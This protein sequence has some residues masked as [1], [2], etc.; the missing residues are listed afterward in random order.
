M[1]EQS[2]AASEAFDTALDQLRDKYEKKAQDDARRAEETRRAASGKTGEEEEEDEDDSEWLDDP[3]LDKIREARLKELKEKSL[4]KREQLSLG[5]GE[6]REINE[7]EFLKE[8]T[9]SELVVCH[10]FHKDFERCKIMD[11]HLRTLCVRYLKTKFVRINA[12][13]SPFFVGKLGVRVLPTV[14]MFIN[15]IV[16]ARITGFERLGSDDFPTAKLER[17]LKRSK[18]LGTGPGGEVDVTDSES[19]DEE[20]REGATVAEI[21]EARRSRVVVSHHAE[22][23]VDDD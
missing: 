3:E 13:K 21:L 1:A 17:H 19:E 9:S 12:E 22:G 11:M 2:G 23:E 14:I 16:K 5:H 15:G 20:R 8:V 18:V 10:F 6:Y 7:E 4:A